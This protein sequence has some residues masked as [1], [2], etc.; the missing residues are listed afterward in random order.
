MLFSS[1]F[2]GKRL[3]F[4]SRSFFPKRMLGKKIKGGKWKHHLRSLLIYVYKCGHTC[5]CITDKYHNSLFVMS[6]VFPISRKGMQ[7]LHF[8][9]SAMHSLLCRLIQTQVLSSSQ[10]VVHDERQRE[11]D[12]SKLFPS[13]NI[14]HVLVTS[15]W[16]RLLPSG[17]S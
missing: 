14:V 5:A 1:A 9:P 13:Q 15:G 11:E 7:A 4:Y 6:T 12:L 3:F 17:L 10:H 16:M 8:P 2:D